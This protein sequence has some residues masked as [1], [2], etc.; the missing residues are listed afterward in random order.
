MRFL[1]LFSGIEAAS[2]AWLPLGWTCV[3]TSEIEGH[4]CAVLAERHAAV[5]NLGDI[6][7]ITEAQVAALGHI[8]LI[9]FGSPCQDLSV[10][11]KRKGFTDA[12]GD[13]TRSGLF[14]AAMR[15]IGWARVHCAAGP[16]IARLKATS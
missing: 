4:P 14:F 12:D 3:G 13:V 2:A 15:V 5:P 16:C 8:D 1:S 6:T 9:V 7:T 11:G 10:A